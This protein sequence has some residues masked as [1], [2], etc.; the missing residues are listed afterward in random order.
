MD[1]LAEPVSITVKHFQI[2]T[3]SVSH[4]VVVDNRMLYISERYD[5][6]RLKFMLEVYAEYTKS[7]GAQ[8]VPFI[9]FGLFSSDMEPILS[10]QRP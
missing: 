2:S 10:F 4:G 6:Q 3:L 1:N 8:S 7:L 9:I 5:Q